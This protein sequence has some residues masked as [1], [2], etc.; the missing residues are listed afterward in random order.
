MQFHFLS[1]LR[2][3]KMYIPKKKPTLTVYS[4]NNKIIQ[5][6]MYNNDKKC[7]KNLIFVF[8]IIYLFK[9][10]NNL[11]NFFYSNFIKENLDQF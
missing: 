11:C 1:F 10:H 8:K 2:L 7:P 5:I 3:L 6:E 9:L 4:N